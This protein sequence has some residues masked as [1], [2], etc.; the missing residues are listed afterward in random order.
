MSMA[1]GSTALS[2]KPATKTG[3]HLSKG[4]M[5]SSVLASPAT[6]FEAPV[7]ESMVLDSVTEDDDDTCEA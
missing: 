3:S 1:I 2:T 4:S 6:E 7:T 5:S